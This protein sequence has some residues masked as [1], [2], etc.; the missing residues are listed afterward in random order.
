MGVS[1]VKSANTIMTPNSTGC[2][3]KVNSA[4]LYLSFL[5]TCLQVYMGSLSFWGGGNVGSYRYMYL[6]TPAGD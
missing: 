1:E 2:T 3:R 4:L 5:I 6:G